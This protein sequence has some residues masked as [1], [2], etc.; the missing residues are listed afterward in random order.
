MTFCGV[1]VFFM[2]VAIG[3]YLGSGG[4]TL[5]AQ[6]CPLLKG[7]KSYLFIILQNQLNRFDRLLL[8]VSV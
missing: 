3:Q 6:L 2:E 8:Q 5:I 1:P 4:M 7:R